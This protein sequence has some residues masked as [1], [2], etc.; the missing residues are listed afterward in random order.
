MKEGHRWMIVPVLG[1]GLMVA[2][3]AQLFFLPVGT[4]IRP[5][6]PA[7]LTLVL[8]L[9]TGVLGIAFATRL[10][11]QRRHARA[12]LCLLASLAPFPLFILMVRLAMLFRNVTLAD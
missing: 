10:F 8:A 1:N 3:W 4:S 9:G 12:T 2:L 7:L 11:L 6:G 5:M